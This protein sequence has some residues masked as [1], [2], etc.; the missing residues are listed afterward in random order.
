MD[1]DAHIGFGV[2]LS[3]WEEESWLPVEA[4]DDPQEWIQNKVL[5]YYGVSP[6]DDW[7]ITAP[8]LKEH[9]P[10]AFGYAGSWQGDMTGVLYYKETKQLAEWG[11]EEIK[12]LHGEEEAREDFTELFDVIGIEKDRPEPTWLFWPTAG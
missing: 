10:F 4:Q 6:E 12:T 11:P 5:E 3:D 1:V 2:I 9:F 8:V 7:R